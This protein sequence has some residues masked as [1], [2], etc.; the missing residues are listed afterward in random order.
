MDF[1]EVHQTLIFKTELLVI[2]KCPGTRASNSLDQSGQ[3]REHTGRLPET[4]SDK[5]EAWL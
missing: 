2:K 5:K 4:T 3:E 1:C